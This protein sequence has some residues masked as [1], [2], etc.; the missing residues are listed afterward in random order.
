MTDRTARK[1]PKWPFLAGDA[2]MLG[3][4]CV[5]FWQSKLPWTLGD[6]GMRG[7]CALGAALGVA[8]FVLEYQP[9]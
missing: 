6:G 9:R 8:P 2:M 5:I 4:A 7:V 3:V 1:F